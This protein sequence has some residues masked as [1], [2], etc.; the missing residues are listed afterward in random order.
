M[1]NPSKSVGAVFE[2]L[3]GVLTRLAS[4]PTEIRQFGFGTAGTAFKNQENCEKQKKYGYEDHNCGNN[5]CCFRLRKSTGYFNR[6]DSSGVLDH[7]AGN[8]KDGA[9][10]FHAH[11]GYSQVSLEVYRE[12]SLNSVV[13]F[14]QKLNSDQMN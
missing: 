2:V 13:V 14:N 11:F 4:T 6:Q 9:G 10:V 12:P 7:V 1:N 8:A 3:N 5:G